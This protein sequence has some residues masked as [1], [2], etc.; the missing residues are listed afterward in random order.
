M[1]RDIDVS[2]SQGMRASCQAEAAR[3]DSGPVI[4]VAGVA[5]SGKTT[6]GRALARH[7][8]LPILDLDTLTNPLLDSL[9]DTDDDSR[10]WL[11]DSD[12]K[13]RAGRYAALLAAAA[14]MVAVGSGVV[15]VAPFTAELTGGDDWDRLCR[16]VS[17]AP[18]EVLYLSGPAALMR[19]RRRARGAARDAFRSDGADAAGASPAVPHL[20]VDATLATAQQMFRAARAVGHRCPVDGRNPVFAADFDALLFDLDGTLV[21]STPAV[22]RIWGL[23][24]DEYGFDAATAQRN[25]GMT[26]L[27]LISKVVRADQVASAH[28]RVTQLEADD[29]HDVIPIVGAE[30][31]LAA[32]PTRASAI[33]TSGGVIVAS[34]RIAAAGLPPVGVL[35]TADDVDRAKPD[36][37][38]FL[39]A[40]ARLGVPASRCLAFEDSPAGS[41]AAKDAGCTVVGV[42]GTCA[43]DELDVDLWLD[44]LDRVRLV[45]RGS[46]YGLEPVG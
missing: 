7:L 22:A 30:A 35:V 46:A 12:P 42:G 28:A 10:H 34:A 18:V 1:S 8:G 44:G 23:L 9:S 3:T 20:V 26:A 45:E 36:P 41:K 29:T 15:L 5:G 33:V 43:P 11:V 25:H 37:Q 31:L 2:Y 13:L 24:G 27:S 38:P 16:A 32:T 14:D 21:D 4:A 17:P 39:L 40:A 6:L 19:Q